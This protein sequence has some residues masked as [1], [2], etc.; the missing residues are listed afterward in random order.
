MVFLPIIANNLGKIAAAAATT[1]GIVG[2]ANR[3][4]I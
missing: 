2:Y 1:S 4:R 3:E